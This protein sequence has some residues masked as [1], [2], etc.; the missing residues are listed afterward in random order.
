MSQR[1]D[2]HVS[3]TRPLFQNDVLDPRL[4]QVVRGGQTSLSGAD[5]DRTKGGHAAQVR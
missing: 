3:L 4:R 2:R 1:R 5:D